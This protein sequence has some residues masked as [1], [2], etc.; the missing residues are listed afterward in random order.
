MAVIL[1]IPSFYA[2][3]VSSDKE[4]ELIDTST[5]TSKN[6]TLNKYGS[7]IYIMESSYT[8]GLSSLATVV[9]RWGGITVDNNYIGDSTLKYGIN[10]TNWSEQNVNTG[11]LFFT[12]IEMENNKLIFVFNCAYSSGINP[13]LNIHL[14]S[15]IGNTKE[16]ILSNLQAKID[17]QN[18]DLTQSF[19]FSD[20]SS[21][22]DVLIEVKGISE[23]NYYLYIDG[24]QK[25]DNSNFTFVNVRYI[26][27]GD[28]FNAEKV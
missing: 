27:W 25:A 15:A 14:I 17:A 11:I 8:E 21:L 26:N 7:K 22:T 18:Y 28:K 16:E 1:N 4:G 3:K 6:E 23:G 24:T 19:T 13:N 10:M 12:P 20:S 2:G 9:E 5:L